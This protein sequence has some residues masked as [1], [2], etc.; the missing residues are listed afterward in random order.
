MATRL[1]DTKYAQVEVLEESGTVVC[2]LKMDYVPAKEFRETLSCIGNYIKAHPFKIHK[3]ILDKRNLKVF[4]Q[5]SMVWYHV[6]WK[7][8]MKQYGLQTYRK[9]LPQ[10][11]F[12]RKAVEIGRKNILKEH[13]EF[14]FEDYDIRYCDTM[15]EALQQTPNELQ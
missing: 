8:E 6:E 13:P 2:I 11:A 7:R 10:D 14:R 9:L 1:L 12:F 5:A 15:E 3:M 4:H